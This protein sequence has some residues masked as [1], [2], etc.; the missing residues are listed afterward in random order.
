MKCLFLL[1]LT[2]FFAAQNNI[3]GQDITYSKSDYD[4][5]GPAGTMVSPNVNFSN[6][7]ADTIEIFV[8]RF[9]K[10]LPQNWTSCFC[11]INCHSPLEDTLR[12]KLGPGEDQTISM[13]FN[14]DSVPGIGYVSI[15]LEQVGGSQKDTIN[16]SAS[17]LV[18]GIKQHAQNSLLNIFPNPFASKV[19]ITS[20]E[21]FTFTVSDMTGKE[22]KIENS[23][24]AKSKSLNLDNFPQ[25]QYLIRMAYPSG[26]TETHKII[27]H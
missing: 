23:G 1:V 10:N 3:R 13:G 25:G 11:F 14:T 8:N 22:L 16:F 17:T 24:T 19:N 15:T 7:G 9:Y 2:L 18:S 5:T 27:K 4:K 20:A 6:T 12:F 26:K 21:E